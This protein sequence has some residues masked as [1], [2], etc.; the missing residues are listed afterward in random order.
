ML[1]HVGNAD[2]TPVYIDMPLIVNVNEK[3]EKTV[4][5]RG[6]GDEKARIAIV[7]GVL[8]DGRKLLPYV[9][10]HQKTMPK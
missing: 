6:K 4:L 1:S 7:V 5:I 9:I 2:Q 10:L 8:A 3:G